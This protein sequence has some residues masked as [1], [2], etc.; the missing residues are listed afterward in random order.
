MQ[1]LTST[2]FVSPTPFSCW[3]LSRLWPEF[4]DSAPGFAWNV[5]VWFDRSWSGTS[6]VSI[7]KSYSQLWESVEEELSMSCCHPSHEWLWPMTDWMQNVYRLFSSQDTPRSSPSC[8]HM[9]LLA[10]F[11][12]KRMSIGLERSLRSRPTNGGKVEAKHLTC[13]RGQSPEVNET[14]TFDES[15]TRYRGELDPDQEWWITGWPFWLHIDQRFHQQMST[16][17][18]EWYVLTL[19]AKIRRMI[20]ILKL[21]EPIIQW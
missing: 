15:L 16:L 1:I 20:R 3:S 17:S 4:L 14:T 5:N 7:V 2:P 11:D 10:I 19:P 13:R 6:N 8:L 12:W 9:I 21:V 18:F